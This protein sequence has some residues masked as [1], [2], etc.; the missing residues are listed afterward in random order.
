[1]IAFSRDGERDSRLI[2]F[3]SHVFPSRALACARFRSLTERIDLRAILYFLDGHSFPR[4]NSTSRQSIRVARADAR[5]GLLSVRSTEI[6][7]SGHPQ[8]ARREDAPSEN[9]SASH[10]EGIL[11]A[12]NHKTE[13][14]SRP[15][16]R[17][18]RFHRQNSL[19]SKDNC[20]GNVNSRRA[21]VFSSAFS[22]RLCRK[23]S[24]FLTHRH[25][26]LPPFR[27]G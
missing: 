20:A 10:R 14:V 27:S 19:T 17:R 11:I 4:L 3:E 26:N 23:L 5:S 7:R 18:A 13:I 16:F 2:S 6:S 22:G 1:M 12:T 24:N 25:S 9:P 21:K 8:E 15:W